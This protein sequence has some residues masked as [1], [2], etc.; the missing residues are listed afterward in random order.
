[1]TGGSLY[2]RCLAQ[3]KSLVT[4]IAERRQTESSMKLQVI[5]MTQD[6]RNEKVVSENLLQ[7]LGLMKV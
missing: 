5:K 7:S 1:M 3:G 2:G 4:P 6:R